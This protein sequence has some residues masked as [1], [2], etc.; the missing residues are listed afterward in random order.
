MF[1]KYFSCVLASIHCALLSFVWNYFSC[2]DN[3]SNEFLYNLSFHLYIILTARLADI[4]LFYFYFIL[5]YLYLKVKSTL[6][7][8]IFYMSIIRESVLLRPRSHGIKKWNPTMKDHH[9]GSNNFDE[10]D[11]IKWRTR[12][13]WLHRNNV[14]LLAHIFLKISLKASQSY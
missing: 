4:F 2:Y 13:D 1:T 7:P 8:I 5:S 14:H 11:G 12:V 6:S 3:S 10:Y 9:H